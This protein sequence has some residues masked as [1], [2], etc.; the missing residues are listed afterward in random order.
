MKT[1]AAKPRIYVKLRAVWGNDDKVST[2]KVSRR[3]WSQI[4]GGAEYDTSAWSWCKGRRSPVSW[5]FRGAKVSVSSEGGMECVGDL[6]VKKLKAWTPHPA[7]VS[8]DQIEKIKYGLHN[9]VS[10]RTSSLL[11]GY[12]DEEL[13]K[14]DYDHEE[15]DRIKTLQDVLTFLIDSCRAYVLVNYATYLDPLRGFKVAGKEDFD[16][17]DEPDFVEY[18]TETYG[19]KF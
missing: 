8:P 1:N 3:R 14:D 10:E 13:A 12:S 17:D 18:L 11:G 6:P 5:Q 4:Q 15:I 9:L 7:K 16:E 2:I 19:I